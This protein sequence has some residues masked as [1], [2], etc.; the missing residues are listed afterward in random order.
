MLRSKEHFKVR[1][2][3]L[4]WFKSHG[5]IEGSKGKFCNKRGIRGVKTTYNVSDRIFIINNFADCNKLSAS[6]LA[7]WTYVVHI[8]GPWQRVCSHFLRFVAKLV[9]MKV[10]HK[11]LPDKVAF[12]QRVRIN[13]SLFDRQSQD[14]V[15]LWD[16]PVIKWDG[17]GSLPSTIPRRSKV[18]NIG[19]NCEI[20][21][22]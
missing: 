15:W 14:W 1:K 17:H 4:Q 8:L 9:W 3:K 11:L 21:S 20:H 12:S 7:N 2:F 18:R 13:T 5:M 6:C 22:R 10:G 19:R 16:N